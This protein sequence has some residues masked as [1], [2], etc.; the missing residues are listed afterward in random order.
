MISTL[1]RFLL[2]FVES[3]YILRQLARH[4]FREYML[5][6]DKI[7]VYAICRP[8]LPELRRVSLNPTL[9]IKDTFVR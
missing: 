6:L 7:V 9:P 2:H 8:R 4:G 1:T 3:G 5:E